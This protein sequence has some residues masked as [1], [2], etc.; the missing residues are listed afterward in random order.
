MKVVI[1]TGVILTIIG[2]LAFSG[3]PNIWQKIVMWL[4]VA[5]TLVGM[6]MMGRYCSIFCRRNHCLADYGFSEVLRS[7]EIVLTLP[8]N[9]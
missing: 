6:V 4:L 2:F 8:S 5:G 9:I 3:L 7:Q 1:P